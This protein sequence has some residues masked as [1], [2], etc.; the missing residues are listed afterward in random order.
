MNSCVVRNC[1]SRGSGS[2][3]M[4]QCKAWGRNSSRSDQPR[5][6]GPI[7]TPGGGF[8]WSW[9]NCSGFFASLSLSDTELLATKTVMNERW[10]KGQEFLFRSQLITYKRGDYNQSPLGY[11]RPVT[12]K[13]KIWKP[14]RPVI[15]AD[16]GVLVKR[17][18]T[19]E[20]IV[21]QDPYSGQ[22]SLKG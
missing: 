6:M 12:W 14:W 15:N 10:K 11:I 8:V 4:I 13:I 19:M 1:H 5:L 18:L 22:I 3:E 7:P 21:Q 9:N 17:L 16:P 20:T 2:R